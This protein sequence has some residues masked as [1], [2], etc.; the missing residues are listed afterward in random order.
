MRMI[1]LS[2]PQ[3]VLA[4]LVRRK[5][6]IIYPFF[7]LSC[8]V[9][10]LTFILP[11]MYVSEALVLIRPRDVPNDLVKDLISGSTE[12]RLSSIRQTVLSRTNLIKILN[13][14]E[15]SMPEYQKLNLDEKVA[16]LRNQITI[17]LRLDSSLGGTKLPLTYFPIS[18]RNRNPQLAQKITAKVTSVFIEQDNLTRETQVSG[19]TQFFSDELDKISTALKESETKLKELKGRRQFELPEQ[20]PANLATLSILEDRRGKDLEAIG[21]AQSSLDILEHT[22]QT[23][24]QTLT[25]LGPTVSTHP[26]PVASVRVQEF[27]SA[28][29]T[30]SALT[31][32]GFTK[33]HPDI[34]TAT[35]H[36]ES[37]RKTLTKADQEYLDRKD[38]KPGEAPVEI[39][40]QPNAE[41]QRLLQ[42]RAELENDIKLAR[43]DLESTA[44]RMNEFNGRVNNTP[45]SEQELADIRRQNDDLNK[46][47]QDTKAKLSQA[48]LSESL[49]TQQKGSQ[50]V[51]EDAANLPLSPSKPVK[52]AIAGIGIIASLLM[53]I[54][55]AIIVDI[56]NQKMWT[57]S[58]VEVFLGT[59]VLVEI[60]EIVIASDLE[61]RLRKRWFHIASFAF[62]AM[63][64]GVSLY[65]AFIHQSFVLRHLDP[66]IKRLY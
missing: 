42:R 30:L 61:A 60:P 51:I 35:N 54:L 1:N 56:A 59:T 43:E 49:E 66:V 27:M 34:I 37:V 12:Q 22:I 64:Y 18:Y 26:Q 33:N 17:D 3:D 65:F 62:L 5:W 4:L 21:R 11:R 20:L 29:S 25:K 45:A 38:D 14:F 63:A 55:I 23:T 31:A 39:E 13:E 24:P 40:T 57:L 48:Q 52:S 44:K 7:A 53:G 50:F 19:T 8:A 46:Q 10:L 6:W 28:Q 58:D 15:D 36:L 2:S 9:V 47:Y 32:K 16:D 41:Y